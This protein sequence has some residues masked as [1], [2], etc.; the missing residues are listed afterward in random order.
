M[1]DECLK[2]LNRLK[3]D[4]VLVDGHSEF[5]NHHKNDIAVQIVNGSFSWKSEVILS[6]INVLIPKSLSVCV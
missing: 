3:S 2:E 5:T 1:I 4:K 6:D